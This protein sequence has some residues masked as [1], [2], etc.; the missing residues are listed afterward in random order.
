MRPIALFFLLVPI[1]LIGSEVSDIRPLKVLFIGNSYTAWHTLPE[2]VAQMAHSKGKRLY[3]EMH[4]PGGRTFE[5]HWNEGVAQEKIQHK[6]WD[7]VMFQNQSFEPVYAPENMRLYGRQLAELVH[8]SGATN[9]YFVTWAYARE[10]DFIKENPEYRRLYVDMQARLNAGYGALAKEVNG[11]LCPVGPAWKVFRE[12]YPEVELH[13]TDASHASPKGAYLSALMMYRVLF[14]EEVEDMP[15]T[16]YPYLDGESFERWGEDIKIE[17]TMRATM[18]ALVNE[19]VSAQAD[20]FRN[21]S[22]ARD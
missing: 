11:L 10:R 5:K 17:T 6:R 20:I 13:H 18:E 14:D 4:A 1:I 8:E 19:V 3:Y 12:R 15:G 2:I 21:K 16:V 22:T 7:Y 9:V